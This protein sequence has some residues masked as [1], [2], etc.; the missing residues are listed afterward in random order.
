[1]YSKYGQRNYE[2]TYLSDV[3]TVYIAYNNCE[4]DPEYSME[5]FTNDVIATINERK[6]RKVIIDLRNNRGGNSEVIQ[7]LL[8]ALIESSTMKDH[9]MAI[10]GRYT[11]SSAMANA[12]QLRSNY[13]AVLVGEPVNG[14]PNKPGDILTFSLPNSGLTVYYST[15]VFHMQN[16]NDT[17]L[18]PN[19]YIEPS[20]KDFKEGNDP[21]LK[22]ALKYDFNNKK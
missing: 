6:A 22:E 17:S 9:I 20:I 5:K 16:K 18:S 7:P 10:T 3:N 1:M 21:V 12:I 8:N 4:I 19:I 11:A 15:K 14:D 2:Y 13:D